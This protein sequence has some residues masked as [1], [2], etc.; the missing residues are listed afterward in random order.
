MLWESELNK[1]NVFLKAFSGILILIIY[2]MD[3]QSRN[4]ESNIF[5]NHLSEEHWFIYILKPVFFQI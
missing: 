3:F 4:I 5:Q 1:I 2:R